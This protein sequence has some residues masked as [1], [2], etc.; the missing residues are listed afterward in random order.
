MTR[1]I[2]HVFG[3]DI[4]NERNVR[5][6]FTRF[7]SGDF[8]L[9]NGPRRRELKVNNDELRATVEVDPLQSPEELGA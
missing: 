3:A 4:T 7:R 2:N 6:R 9:T 1:N 8:Y 5:F